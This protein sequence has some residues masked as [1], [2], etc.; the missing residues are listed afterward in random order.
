[1]ASEFYQRQHARLL[2][3]RTE[4]QQT[5]QVTKE[6]SEAVTL[7]QSRV[8][9]LSRMDAMQQQAMSHARERRRAQALVAIDAA[10]NRLDN[11]AYGECTECGE[12]IARTRLEFNP[13]VAMCLECAEAAESL[14]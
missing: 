10:L 12:D 3:Q 2:Q 5:S 7:D 13:A 1:M 4:L 14:N 8:G 6:S 11:G 9:R